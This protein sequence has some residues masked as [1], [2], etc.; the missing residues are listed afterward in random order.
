[1]KVLVTAPVKDEQ[2]ARI[3]AVSEDFELVV[4]RTPE[5]EERHL[6]D[7]EVIFGRFDK[8]RFQKARRLKW[9]QVT[10]AGVDPLMFDE[11]VRSKVILTSAKGIVGTHLADHA[12]ALLLALVR[13]L[14]TA[15]ETKDWK[16]RGSADI[17]A[18]E[19]GG[20]TMGLVGLGGT[21][22][23][24]AKRAQGFDMRVIAIDPEDVAKPPYVAELWKPDR[25]YDLL[26]QS[27]V[28]VICCPLTK[29][30]AGMF[31]LEAFRRM[32]RGSILIN[33]TRGPIVDE[34]ALM[35]A[36]KEK[37]IAAAGLDVLPQEP[38]PPDHPLWMMPNVIVTPHSAGRSPLRMDRTVDLFAENLRRFLAG[39]PMLSVIDKSKEY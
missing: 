11:F 8:E 31:N 36:L 3:R 25:F 26:A 27:D 35:Q 21:G 38:L 16:A 22:I 6:P 23:E 24:V 32:K 9:V 2:V 37:L 4:A 13:D 34:A 15:I 1:M 30:T 29:K 12:F 17:S 39:K 7:A 14:K 10:P 33:V 18:M 5:E 20:K 19:L 28:V